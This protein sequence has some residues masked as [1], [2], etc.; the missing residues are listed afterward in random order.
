MTDP[1]H[2]DGATAVVAILCDVA[3]RILRGCPLQTRKPRLA[4]AIHPIPLPA[5][6]FY[7]LTLYAP[8]LW[9]PALLRGPTARS[10]HQC[11]LLERFARS[12]LHISSSSSS[13]P[14]RLDS[15][16]KRKRAKARS[17]WA[18]FATWLSHLPLSKSPF[19]SLSHPARY[20]C[21]CFF[22]LVLLISLCSTYFCGSFVRSGWDWGP[23]S[24][25][26]FVFLLLAPVLN[27]AILTFLNGLSQKVPDYVN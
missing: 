16:G 27:Y 6:S 10:G 15:H 21:A 17:T 19:P 2:C 8:C 20:P 25:N 18:P 9:A 26:Y 13:F 11:L 23:R 5:C 24:E 1:Y 22:L 7:H 12:T 4:S 3:E 14:P